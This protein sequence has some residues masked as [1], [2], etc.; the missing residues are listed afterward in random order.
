MKIILHGTLAEQFGREHEIIT[1]VPADAIEG[2]SRQLPEWPRDLL[3]DVIG[4]GTDELL[5]SET[6][7]T[8]IHL[9]PAMHGGGGVGKII[10]GVALIAAAIFLPAAFV[11]ATL[12]A[13]MTVGAAMFTVGVM[14]VLMGVSQ[15]FMKAPT[16][17]KTDDP[18]ASK[19]LGINKNTASIGTIIPYAY[20]RMKIAGH[21]LS[22]Q[23]NSSSLVTTSFPVNPT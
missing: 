18:P 15:L 13:G 3:I 6:D 20:G 9:V 8:E 7:A 17:D 12:V 22:I 11:G 14:L 23:V 21:W 16:I 2:L 1:R 5:K 10:L 19:Y 4:F